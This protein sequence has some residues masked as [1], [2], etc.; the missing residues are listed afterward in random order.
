MSIC[1]KELAT[2]FN[3]TFNE[4]EQTILM[5]TDDEPCYLPKDEQYPFNRI[6]YTKDSYTSL[7]HEV[8]HWC[9]AGKERRQLPD[10]GYWYQAEDRSPEAQQLYVAS[11]SKTQALEWI[12]CVAAG[13]CIQIIPENQPYSFKP[14]LEFRKS[15]YMAVLHYLQKGLSDRPERFKQALLNYYRKH[16]VFNESLF[17]FEDLK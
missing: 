13:V 5:A 4:S 9:R 3:M 14:S 6:Y 8:A 10:Y 15:I 12:F 1:C 16:L 2:V 17:L 11:E 7:M